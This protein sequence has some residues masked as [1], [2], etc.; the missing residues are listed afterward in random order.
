MNYPFRNI[1]KHIWGTTLHKFWVFNYMFKFALKLIW[2]GLKH[3]LSK[4]SPVECRGFFKTIDKLKTSRY[5][6]LEYHTLLDEIKPSLNHHYKKN[7]HHPEYHKN[8]INDFNLFDLVEMACD[9]KSSVKRHKNGDIHQSISIN[10]NRFEIS[11]QVCNILK[12]TLE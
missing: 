2:R 5:G 12:N 10:K 3:D 4:Y 7:A 6:T 8:G 1:I 11:D 9:W